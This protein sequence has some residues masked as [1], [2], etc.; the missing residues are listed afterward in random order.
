MTRQLTNLLR[1]SPAGFG[2]GQLPA[3]RVPDAT[4]R[5]TCGYCS[6]GCSLDIHLRDGKA[7]G[8]SPTLENPVN[9]GA[10]C[11]KGWEALAPLTAPD[12]ATRPLL[13]D[14]S[15]RLRPIAWNDALTVF[16]DRMKAIQAEHGPDSIAFISTGQIPSEEMALLGALAKFGMGTKHGDGNTRQCMASA[17]VA[18]K[19][20]F[21]FDAPPYTYADFE[22]SDVIVLVGS[23]LCVAHPIMWDRITQNPN[24]PTI[25]VVDPRRTET[26]MAAT[27]HVALRPKSDLALLYGL[28]NLLIGMGAVDT[29]FVAEHTNGFD[30][31]AGFVADFT[32]ERV[33]QESG[34]A[35]DQVHRIAD[36][37]A[38]G[39][40]VSFWWTMGVNQSHQGVRTAQSLI[41][42]ALMT[43]NIGRPGTGANSITGQCNAMGSRLFSNTTGL[44]GGYDFAVPEHRTHVAE[45]LDIDEDLIPHEPSWSYDRIVEGIA[46]GEIHGLWVIA[47][48]GAHSWINHSDFHQLL[49]R[50]DFLVVQ[51][52]YTT[53]ET[54]E[55]AD[56]VLPAAGWA[57]KEGTFINSERRLGMVKRVVEAPGEALA[58]FYIF[59]AI[60]DRWGCGDLFA[61]WTDPEATFRVLQRLTEGRPCDL[62][63]V[64]GYDHVDKG[65]VQWP[66]P[67]VASPDEL[68]GVE[69]GAA[70]AAGD[71]TQRRLFADRRFYHPDGRAKFLFEEPEVPL[72]VPSAA[73]PLVLLTGRGSAS[74]WHTET[75]TR[76]SAT[77]R[78]LAPDGL[79]LEMHPDDA[80]PRGLSTGDDVHV[81]SARGS[82]DCRVLVVATVPAGSVFLPMHDKRVNRLT[83][84]AFDSYSRQPSYKYCAVE[85]R[86]AR[87]DERAR[88]RQ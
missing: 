86:A 44:L 23:N 60:A 49:D 10:A 36:A 56:L 45:V 63:G 9:G 47:T 61:D 13:R 64:E 2:L 7:V 48:N 51:D 19:Q 69:P 31:F 4:T 3:D 42:L 85:V 78:A 68:P 29:S 21:G 55:R 70:G 46:R 84:P 54:A 15:G 37:I 11:P 41:N 88:A 28:A 43:G 16:C 62:T 40:A 32:L 17:V 57:E 59:K 72:E 71:P 34:V 5:M 22:T 77:L 27:E 8:L 83:F 30:D 74:Q 76:K 66:Y 1:R 25:I 14:G 82:V 24:D 80:T 75:R 12:R 53:T 20:S 67:A 6:T 52:L 50:L 58:D 39:E 33:E 87:A 79:W 26:A 35:P 73:R 81:S 18:Y 65:T 38:G